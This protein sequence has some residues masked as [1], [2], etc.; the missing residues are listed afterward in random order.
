VFAIPVS[1]AAGVALSEWPHVALSARPDAPLSARPRA[2]L[3]AV[4][5][6]AALALGVLRI[7]LPGT[8]VSQPVDVASVGR[9]EVARCVFRW[10]GPRAVPAPRAPE[11]GAAQG[12]SGRLAELTQVLADRRVEGTAALERPA[13]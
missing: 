5:A 6:S 13:Q 10:R 7:A 9:I 12:R 1:I 2:A 8:C 3:A 11:H 4:C